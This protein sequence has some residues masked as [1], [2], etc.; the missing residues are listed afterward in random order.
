MS[1]T[2]KMNQNL[3]QNVASKEPKVPRMNYEK[4]KRKQANEKSENFLQNTARS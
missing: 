3:A 2:Q 1:F 4:E